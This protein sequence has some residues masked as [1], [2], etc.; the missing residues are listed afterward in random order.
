MPTAPCHPY[1]ADP[2]FL[3]LG[4]AEVCMYV[5]HMTMT[6]T[7]TAPDRSGGHASDPI[8][9]LGKQAN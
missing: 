7:M 1:L 3:E 2:W 8:E 5:L 9:Y 4:I 6:L